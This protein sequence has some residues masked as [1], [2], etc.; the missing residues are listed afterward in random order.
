MILYHIM[1]YSYYI[2]IFYQSPEAA[3]NPKQPRA[4]RA[5]QKLRSKLAKRSRRA[6]VL[7]RHLIGSQV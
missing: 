6:P 5:L 2:I 1:P 4:A 7:G 3:L